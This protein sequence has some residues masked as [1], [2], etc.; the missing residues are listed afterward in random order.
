MLFDLQDTWEWD[1]SQQRR[2]GHTYS[3]SWP[4][5]YVQDGAKLSALEVSWHA[6]AM[7]HEGDGEC[8]AEYG[9]EL[10]AWS[11]LGWT[12]VAT[13]EHGPDDPEALAWSTTDAGM[14][15]G[16]FFGPPGHEAM[17]FAVTPTSP[18]GCGPEYGMVTTDYVE[19]TVGYR[20]LAELP[21][22]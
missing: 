2:P 12:S 5:A 9:A 1:A 17:K 14:I 6:G 8:L 20:L 22:E 3:V 16:V 10:E 11:Q 21:A 7:G 15:H 13:T 4:H 18:N 19:V